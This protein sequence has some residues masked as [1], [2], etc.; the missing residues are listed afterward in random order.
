MHPNSLQVSLT[1]ADRPESRPTEYISLKD[2]ARLL[3][4]CIADP[5]VAPIRCTDK[6][7]FKAIFK[8]RR[9]TRWKARRA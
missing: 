9:S 1:G 8:P 7:A 3:A 2:A 6:R 4:E 5:L